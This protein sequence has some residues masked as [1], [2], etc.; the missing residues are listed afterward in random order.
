MP[1]ELDTTPL[2]RSIPLFAGLT[3][4]DLD[5][6]GRALVPRS[7]AAGDMVRVSTRRGVSMK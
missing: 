4:E 1:H 7:F 3:D 5:E 6:L 2:L